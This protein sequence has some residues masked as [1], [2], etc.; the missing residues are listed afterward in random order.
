MPAKTIKIIVTDVTRYGTL[1]C[2]A[3]W[4]SANSRMIR[5]LPPTSGASE[6]SHFWG[7]DLAG[8][9][10]VFFPGA[11]VELEGDSYAGYENPHTTEDWLLTH[12]SPKLLQSHPLSKIAN[13]APANLYTT[14]GRAFGPA[15]KRQSNGKAYVPGG[16]GVRSLA[17]VNVPASNIS[18]SW[19]G[20]KLRARV[21]DA[22]ALY[23][24]S[25]PSDRL[26]S[27][28][29][30]G[31]IGSVRSEFPRGK[32]AHVR[33]GLARRFPEDQCYLQVNDI[34]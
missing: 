6:S 27:L 32:T 14:V 3:G 22:Y 31:G 24:C 30:A 15:L 21:Q 2:V 4:D 13:L 20:R 25:A 12:V 8:H 11:E 34:Y 33:F 29:Q 19:D 7:S 28:V 9:G 26:I 16:S 23:D 18:F 17:A 1:F 5:P 10:R